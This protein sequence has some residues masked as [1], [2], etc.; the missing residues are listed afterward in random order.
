MFMLVSLF[1]MFFI[2]MLLLLLQFITSLQ[3]VSLLTFIPLP[4][5]IFL[6]LLLLFF[7]IF[8]LFFLQLFFSFL[9]F[10]IKLAFVDNGQMT[11]LLSTFFAKELFDVFC[12]FLSNIDAVSMIPLLTVI[13]PNHKP[14]YVNT[15]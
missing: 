9:N 4:V 2:L 12:F 10:L 15:P 6:F 7:L 5:F 14:V 3:P 13:T 11:V 8:M 1:I